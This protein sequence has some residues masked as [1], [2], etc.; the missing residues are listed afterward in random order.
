MTRRTAS[1]LRRRHDY[2]RSRIE[3]QMRISFVR[4]ICK[5]FCAAF[6]ALRRRNAEPRQTRSRYI[7][8]LGTLPNH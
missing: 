3:W 4:Y 8:R 7:D 2:D 1:K 6:V 5:Q